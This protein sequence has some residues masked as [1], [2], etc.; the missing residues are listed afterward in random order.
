MAP[1]T[2]IIG[3]NAGH[4]VRSALLIEQKQLGVSPDIARVGRN[5]KW[6][7]ADQTQAVAVSVRLKPLALA[8]EQELREAGLAN[9]V[10]KFA[11]DA[12]KRRPIALNKLCRPF[13]VIRV[14]ELRF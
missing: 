11:P 4:K 13:E 3:G 6:Q 12:V 14:V 2:E 9:L 7:V 8:E 1:R 5:E 10:C